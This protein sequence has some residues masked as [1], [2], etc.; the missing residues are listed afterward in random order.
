MK[1][2]KYFEAN[3]ETHPEFAEALKDAAASGVQLLAI[4]CRIT[5]D[6]IQAADTVE[7]RL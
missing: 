4:D 7:I 5:S 6:S 1:N 3:R 2:V